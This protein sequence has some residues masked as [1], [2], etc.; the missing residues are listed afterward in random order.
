[1]VGISTQ[2]YKGWWFNPHAHTHKQARARARTHIHA[3][4]QTRSSD[5][6]SCILLFYYNYY[7]CYFIFFFVKNLRTFYSNSTSYLDW[8]HFSNPSPWEISHA[9]FQFSITPAIANK[10]L[11]LF[12]PPICAR[13]PCRSGYCW[14]SAHRTQLHVFPNEFCE[15]R[16]GDYKV[17]TRK[18]NKQTH[19]R[20]Y[21]PV[22]WPQRVSVSL[23]DIEVRWNTEH[24]CFHPRHKRRSISESSEG[25]YCCL[26][27]LSAG[28][29][30]TSYHK[31]LRLHKKSHGW[32]WRLLEFAHYLS[33]LVS[34]AA[35][36]NLIERA[37]N[38]V[39][40]KDNDVVIA[41]I[42]P[43]NR[44]VTRW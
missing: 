17:I 23:L 4:T 37:Q 20:L 24:L 33:L 7:C 43:V 38:R 44:R 34:P 19:T 22:T 9:E 13:S 3:H 2:E 1:V 25:R 32:W 14:V 6:K 36:S 15:N 30:N 8:R 29:R 41:S 18:L 31:L 11:L 28:T 10:N 40:S 5:Q 16:T 26:S 12:L 35:A 21:S 27:D 39:P 42:I